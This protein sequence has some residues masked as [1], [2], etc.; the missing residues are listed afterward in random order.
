M[1]R[2]DCPGRPA[3]VFRLSGS[4]TSSTI[5]STTSR[6][7]RHKASTMSRSARPW[8]LRITS[9]AICSAVPAMPAARW[10]RVPAAA[11]E[12]LASSVLQPRRVSFSSRI[13]STPRR[14]A[15]NAAMS[16]QA[17]API[18]TRSVSRSQS[19][20]LDF[21]CGGKGGEPAEPD[22][23][24]QPVAREVAERAAAAADP[25]GRSAAG[26]EIGN[27][28]AFGRKHARIGVGLQ[29]ALRVEQPRHHLRGPV[30]RLERRH[31][32]RRAAECVYQF[33]S[34]GGVV[35]FYG[36]NQL[37]VQNGGLDSPV[38]EQ[39]LELLLA[40]RVPAD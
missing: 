12:P 15:A 40:L 11:I 31:A 6:A 29:P 10:K 30:R 26:E 16:P 4:P 2:N 3:S 19:A 14:A 22:G 34:G 25:G 23:A 33:V 37:S 13:S 39:L 32:E 1:R 5:R 36:F 38:F 27:R 20:M 24:Q 9:S 7:L 35:G 17:P 21:L 8:F 28:L 18:T